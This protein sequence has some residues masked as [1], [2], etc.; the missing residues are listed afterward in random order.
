MIP[1]GD[2]L[3]AGVLG[4]EWSASPGRTSDVRKIGWDGFNK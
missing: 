4:K 1:C 2:T 3:M